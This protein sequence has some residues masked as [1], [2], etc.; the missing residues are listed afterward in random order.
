MGDCIEEALQV[1]ID[2]VSIAVF[3]GLPHLSQ[4][5]MRT[6]AR[7]EAVA[8]CAEGRL[9]QRPDNLCDCLLNHP[10]QHRWDTQ[11]PLASGGFGDHHPANCRRAIGA[12]VQG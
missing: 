7:P 10:I 1:A 5:H 6:L 11:R 3:M 2:C 9:E 8:V 12:L 4:R